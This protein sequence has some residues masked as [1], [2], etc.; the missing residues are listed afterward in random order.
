MIAVL[1]ETVLFRMFARTGI[2]LFNEDS[3]RWLYQAYA[4]A[5]WFGNSAIC[6]QVR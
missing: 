5:V 2:Y 3:P 6:S 1:L 4:S